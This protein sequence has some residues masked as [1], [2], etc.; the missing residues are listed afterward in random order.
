MAPAAYPP[1]QRLAYP[2]SM[3][4]RV[5]KGALGMSRDTRPWAEPTISDGLKITVAAAL[6]VATLFALLGSLDA[7]S[8]WE[9]LQH[10]LA[11]LGVGAILPVTFLLSQLFLLSPRP[12]SLAQRRRRRKP[13]ATVA[14]AHD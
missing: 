7:Q 3:E 2:A 5:R 9:R 4:S 11:G 12:K 8:T 13:A 10:L 1:V 6:L 14:R